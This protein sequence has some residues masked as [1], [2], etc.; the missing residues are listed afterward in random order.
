MGQHGYTTVVPHDA[1][2][3]ERTPLLDFEAGYVQRSL[4]LFPQAGAEA[5]WRLGMSYAQDVI[6]LRH[7]KLDDGALRFS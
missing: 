5:P 4:H 7:G 1:T 3:V 2:G 6:T